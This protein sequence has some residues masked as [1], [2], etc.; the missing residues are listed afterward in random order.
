MTSLPFWI[1]PQAELLPSTCLPSLI[2]SYPT[3]SSESWTIMK[4]PSLDALGTYPARSWTESTVKKAT[5]SSVNQ[6]LNELSWFLNIKSV[7]WAAEWDQTW[8]KVVLTL[9]IGT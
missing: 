8:P 6:G 9:L 1:Q 5:R 2:V 3:L 7:L 4:S